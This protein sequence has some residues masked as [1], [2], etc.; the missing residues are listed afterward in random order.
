MSETANMDV[1]PDSEHRGIVARLPQ[2][3]RDLG[4]FRSAD[5]LVGPV[6][7]LRLGRVADGGGLAIGTRRLAPSREH[8]HA[9]RRLRL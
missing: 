8:R 5:R 4:A 7:A 9:R 6:L 1:V 3:P 2:V